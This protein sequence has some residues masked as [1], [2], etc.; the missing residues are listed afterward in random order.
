MDRKHYVDLRHTYLALQL[1]FVKGPGYKTYSRKD[2][3]QE[4]KEAAKVD[5]ETTKEEKQEAPVPLATHSN[6]ISHSL[7]SN[8]EVYINNEQTSNSNGLYEHKCYI[9]NKFKGAISEYEWVLHCERYD[10]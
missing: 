4:H 8:A 1:N 3:E 7:F 9:S 2:I 5:E 6:N 10:Y